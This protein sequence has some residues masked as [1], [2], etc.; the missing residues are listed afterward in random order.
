LDHY[1]IYH[2]ISNIQQK[3]HKKEKEK[4]LCAVGG[5][6]LG[7]QAGPC[8]CSAHIRTA[9]TAWLL[10]PRAL[11][12]DAAHA[13]VARAPLLRMVADER[14]PLVSFAFLAHGGAAAA[15]AIVTE[16]PGPRAR[17][18]QH[19]V[20]PTTPRL[21]LTDALSLSFHLNHTNGGRPRRSPRTGHEGSVEREPVGPGGPRRSGDHGAHITTAGEAVEKLGDGGRAVGRML[22]LRR[23]C[24]GD[25]VGVQ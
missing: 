22:R 7:P 23:G 20:N 17:A 9:R 25:P 2:I 3:L 6:D 15:P 11:R 14:V 1:T 21:P 16:F 8:A 18:H 19:R 10:G 13:G 5:L 24:S 12:L 4:E